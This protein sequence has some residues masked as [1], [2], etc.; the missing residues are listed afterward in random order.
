M[1]L[2]GEFMSRQEVPFAMSGRRGR[3]G[4]GRQVVQLRGPIVGALWHG[5]LLNGPMGFLLGTGRPRALI[6]VYLRIT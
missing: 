2:L 3:M 1:R 5:V 6:H 4:V